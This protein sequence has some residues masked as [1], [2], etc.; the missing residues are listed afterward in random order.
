MA[1]KHNN[2]GRSKGDGGFIRL[3]HHMVETPAWRSLPVYERAA[4]VEIAQLYNGSNNGYLGMGVRRLADRLNVSPNK[5][6]WCI[7]TLIERGFIEVT[8]QSGYSRK[9]RKQS[10]FRLTQYR[11]DRTHHIGSRAFQNWRETEP[12]KK[13]TVARGERTVARGGTV[14]PSQSHVV[15]LSGPKQAPEGTATVAR[16]GTHI[17]IHHGRGGSGLASDRPSKPS[18]PTAVQNR[19]DD[20]RKSC[21]PRGPVAAGRARQ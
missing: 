10:E 14:A 4:Y 20:P 9:D 6:A 17:D 16:G 13:S 18:I 2:K 8:E 21:G 7:Q 5:A 19:A 12:E 3:M 11:C 15:V 1:R